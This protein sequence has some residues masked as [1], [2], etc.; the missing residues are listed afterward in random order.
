MNEQTPVYK[1]L[2]EYVEANK[3][4]Q[5]VIAANMGYTESQISLL[6]N[7][8]RRLTV[9]DYLLFCRAIAVSPTRFIPTA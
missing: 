3:L 4:S 8:K 1:K 6:L 5:K 7:G 2:S 9:E